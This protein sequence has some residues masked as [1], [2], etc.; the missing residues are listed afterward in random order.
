M[1]LNRWIN[2]TVETIN[3][4]FHNKKVIYEDIQNKTQSTETKYRR[5]VKVWS[6]KESTKATDCVIQSIW[7][8]GRGKTTETVERSVVAKGTGGYKEEG[9]LGESYNNFKAAK[10]FPTF[11]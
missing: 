9:W 8:S 7:Y 1:T 10:L 2:K 6:V 3:E 5:T 4:I 11:L